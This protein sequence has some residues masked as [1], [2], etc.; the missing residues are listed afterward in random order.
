MTNLMYK[1]NDLIRKENIYIIEYSNLP[2]FDMRKNEIMNKQISFY[3]KDLD[4]LKDV[5]ILT[6]NLFDFIILNKIDIKINQRIKESKD[7]MY[8]LEV[9]GCFFLYFDI[10]NNDK[11]IYESLTDRR[12]AEWNNKK[13]SQ[14]MTFYSQGSKK[15][16]FIFKSYNNELIN[17]LFIN[18]SFVEQQIENLKNKT[19]YEKT[20]INKGTIENTQR[21]SIHKSDENPEKKSQDTVFLTNILTL[22]NDFQ[23]KVAKLIPFSNNK[24][25]HNLSLGFPFVETNNNVI[26]DKKYIKN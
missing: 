5:L 22:N 21:Q 1:I 26:K 11:E 17:N 10:K 16:K 23:K 15:N 18:H 14:R 19:F 24:T 4:V 6:Q 13:L 7:Y 2:N 8:F 25:T 3:D 20:L 9:R 12:F